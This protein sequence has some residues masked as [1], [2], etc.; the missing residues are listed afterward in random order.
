MSELRQLRRTA[1]LGQREFA[2]LLSVP[3]ETFRTWDSGRRPVP[4]LVLHQAAAAIARHQRQCELL[5]LDQL[6]RELHVHVR[7]LQAA[8]R[9]GRLDAT[10]SV[11]C[12]FGRP[13]R[14]ATRAA[15]E[16]FLALC[17]GRCVRMA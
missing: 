11:R 10:F 16:R 1:G 13:I 2:A 15:G 14:Y 4:G 5:P 17:A 9:T 3:L 7:T 12:V 6:A 8:A